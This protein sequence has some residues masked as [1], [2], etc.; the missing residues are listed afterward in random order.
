M[1]PNSKKDEIIAIDMTLDLT[2]PKWHQ[3]K[4]YVSKRRQ[5]SVD[6]FV[7]IE[8][9]IRCLYAALLVRKK[10]MELSGISLEEQHFVISKGG[11]PCLS[12][13]DLFFNLSHSGDR[14]FACFAGSEIG[15]DVE[16]VK[17]APF[18]VMK[19]VF[20]DAEIAYV[21]SAD[22]PITKNERFF[23]VWTCKEAFGKWKGN[24]IIYDLPTLNTKSQ[25]MSAHLKTWFR[26]GYCYSVYMDDICHL[27]IIRESN[28][29]VES[30]YQLY[31]SIS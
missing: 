1:R 28:E 2:N 22:N 5:E 25:T 24:G 13:S 7:H 18:Y 17:D 12:D 27:T 26:E 11:K 14:V 16:K 4:K 8:D 15:V 6:R 9:K 31:C 21:E 20:H 23:E 19:N 3:Y 29:S 10:C 30:F